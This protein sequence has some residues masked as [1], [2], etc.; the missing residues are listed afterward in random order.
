[1][2]CVF[3]P[4]SQVDYAENDEMT[5]GEPCVDQGKSSAQRKPSEGPQ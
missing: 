1:M 3:P 2:P 4:Y 5:A